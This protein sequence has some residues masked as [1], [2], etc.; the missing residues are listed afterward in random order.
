MGKKTDLNRQIGP[1]ETE[2]SMCRKQ[3]IWG[4]GLTNRITKGSSLEV[5]LFVVRSMCVKIDLESS[6][7]METEVKGWDWKAGITQQDE[8]QQ[9][10]VWMGG[11]KCAGVV[12]CRDRAGETQQDVQ[13]VTHTVEKNTQW[14]ETHSG[15]V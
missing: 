7:E 5:Q 15:T 8:T 13:S 14:R 3:E 2:K 6:I 9:D 11:D 4:Q 10:N 1:N 12:Q